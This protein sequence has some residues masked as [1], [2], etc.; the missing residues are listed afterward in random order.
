MGLNFFAGPYFGILVSAKE[1]LD[2]YSYTTTTSVTGFPALNTSNTTTYPSGSY[3]LDTGS[4]MSS[5]DMGIRLGA[6]FDLP[7]GLG[8]TA[9]YNLGLT[10]LFPSH[11]YGT[12]PYTV[13]TPAYGKNG[14]I[15]VSIRYLFGIGS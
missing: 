14:V 4:I 10:T 8:F 5:M 15:T 13:T 11:T 12:A 9:G 1:S 2:G 3:K 7:M 6:G